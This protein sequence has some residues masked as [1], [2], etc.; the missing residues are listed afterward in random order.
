MAELTPLERFQVAVEVAGNYYRDFFYAQDC[1][2]VGFIT[3]CQGTGEEEACGGYWF[4]DLHTV[5]PFK[6]WDDKVCAAIA[7]DFAK[8]KYFE[9]C[10]CGEDDDGDDDD[11][12]YYK[13]DDSLSDEENEAASEKFDEAWDE[14]E[15]QPEK[16]TGQEAF[17]AEVDKEFEKELKAAEK[18][19]DKLGHYPIKVGDDKK[20]VSESEVK[21]YKPPKQ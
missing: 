21:G 19:K 4:I 9:D 13:C 6:S 10:I 1:W 18:L 11:E 17:Q 12:E 5:I 7:G 16:L 2:E 15:A 20:G 3:P 14:G 8:W